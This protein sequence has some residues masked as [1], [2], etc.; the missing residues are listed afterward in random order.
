MRAKSVVFSLAA[1]VI[2]NGVAVDQTV[3][4]QS[5]T[6]LKTATLQARRTVE[7]RDNYVDAAFSFEHG[8]NSEAG[9]KLTRNDW[10]LLFGNKPD[11]D[12]F[13]VTMVTD[14]CSRIKDLGEI[15]WGARYRVRPLPAHSTPTKEPGV[16]AL[17]GHMYLVHT[18]DQDTDL[19]AL[20]RVEALEPGKSVT[21]SWRIIPPPEEQRVRP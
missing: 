6:E 13:D 1:A 7:G 5:R 9:R 3:S 11:E 10:D 15:N 14:D 20:F 19:Y 4:G 16:R 18:A 21:I 17:V 2:L 8:V 12:T